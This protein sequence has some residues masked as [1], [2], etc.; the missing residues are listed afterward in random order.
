MYASSSAGTRSHSSSLIKSRV[1]S[2]LTSELLH[3]LLHCTLSEPGYLR[4]AQEALQ[5]VTFKSGYIA[6][7][8]IF[9]AW[10]QLKITLLKHS[11]DYMYSRAFKLTSNI[12]YQ[13]RLLLFLSPLLSFSLSHTHMHTFFLHVKTIIWT[14]VNRFLNNIQYADQTKLYFLYLKQNNIKDYNDFR[15]CKNVIDLGLK[16]YQEQNVNKTLIKAFEM[17]VSSKSNGKEPSY[18]WM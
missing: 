11:T 7:T 5:R 6:D 15:L 9:K 4:S 16:A 17:Y 18:W 14:T 8:E 12:K 13:N 1:W 2:K 10:K 3:Q